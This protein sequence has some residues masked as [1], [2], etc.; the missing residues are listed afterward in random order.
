MIRLKAYSLL[1]TIWA[2][3]IWGAAVTQ[4]V[5][6]ADCVSI[7]EANSMSSSC[8]CSQITTADSLHGEPTINKLPLSFS[9]AYLDW[10]ASQLCMH[11][12]VS[13][14]IT[15]MWDQDVS[16]LSLSSELPEFHAI[17][18]DGL[19]IP[20]RG[21][22]AKIDVIYTPR[23]LGPVESEIVF[24]TSA[25]M[26]LY[27]VKGEGMRN[28][29]KVAPL[30]GFRVPSGMK[31]M[32]TVELHNPLDRPLSIAEIYPRDDF[33]TLMLPAG[34]TEGEVWQIPPHASQP[35]LRLEF[36]PKIAGRYQSSIYV[37]TDADEIV[38]PVEIQAVKD[39]GLLRLEDKLDFGMLTIPYEWRTV[40]LTLLNSGDEPVKILQVVSWVK[41][42]R[43]DVEMKS[44]IVPPA[45]GREIASITF[46][47]LVDGEFHGSVMVRTNDTSSAGPNVEVPYVANVLFGSLTYNVTETVFP[48]TRL[49][50]DVVMN[51]L[52]LHNEFSVP[53]SVND[54]DIGDPRFFIQD[55]VSGG[56]LAPGEQRKVAVI[57]FRSTTPWPN[58]PTPQFAATAS[59]RA[60]SKEDGD[61]EEAT[62]DSSVI[63]TG[64]I[65]TTLTLYTN[66][67]ALKIPL[68]T[69]NGDMV[70]TAS[71]LGDDK[72]A[73]TLEPFDV[74]SVS[75]HYRSAK[76]PTSSVFGSSSSVA[77]HQLKSS[78]TIDFG[79]L[80]VGE[81][82]YKV[83]NITNFNPVPI[84][85][86]TYYVAGLRNADLTFLGYDWSQRDSA[87]D[88]FTN[89]YCFLYVSCVPCW[90]EE[91]RQFAQVVQES[92]KEFDLVLP[93]GVLE[94]QSCVCGGTSGS[95]V[96][97]LPGQVAYFL[98]AIEVDER[99]SW[100]SKAIEGMIVFETGAARSLNEARFAKSARQV[101]SLV[102]DVP[103]A[104]L[105]PK[106]SM[107]INVR[108][109]AVMGELSVPFGGDIDMG[110]ALPGVSLTRAV[111]ASSTY[112]LPARILSI[113]LESSDPS[114]WKVHKIL[115]VI[116]NGDPPLKTIMSDGVATDGTPDSVGYHP[117]ATVE[118]DL[119]WSA[120]ETLKALPS[121]APQPDDPAEDDFDNFFAH[122]TYWNE[123][124]SSTK[125]DLTANISI[126][127]DIFD[128][129][130]HAHASYAYPRLAGAA[131]SFN[132]TQ[133]GTRVSRWID[134]TNPTDVPITC[135]LL[136]LD[137]SRRILASVDNSI[138]V[139]FDS[140]D[141]DIPAE[142]QQLVVLRPRSSGILGP[143]DFS[144][145]QLGMT[146]SYVFIK[147]NLTG[148]EKIEVVGRGGSG[149][150]SVEPMSLSLVFQDADLDSGVSAAVTL[151]NT[152]DLALLVLGLVVSGGD[153][154]S[155]APVPHVDGASWMVG[156]DVDSVGAA[157][158]SGFG[159]EVSPCHGPF[160]LPPGAESVVNITWR[161]EVG[162]TSQGALVSVETWTEAVTFSVEAIA[163]AS[164]AKALLEESRLA[165]RVQ[166]TGT[167]LMLVRSC[168]WAL[169]AACLWVIVVVYQI[170]MYS[171]APPPVT[172][173][174]PSLSSAGL[175]SSK[176]EIDAALLSCRGHADREVQLSEEVTVNIDTGDLNLSTDLAQK[177]PADISGHPVPKQEKMIGDLRDIR[178]QKVTE[179]LSRRVTAISSAKPED[180]DAAAHHEDSTDG[181][182]SPPASPTEE[183][184][185][186]T[187]VPDEPKPTPKPASSSGGDGKDNAGEPP[188]PTTAQ[189][190]PE[191]VEGARTAAEG[192]AGTG[193][194][195]APKQRELAKRDSADDAE[196]LAPSGGKHTGHPPPGAG[197]A[198]G[199][200]GSGRSK[201]D[202]S[203]RQGSTAEPT[204]S[205]GKEK[206]APSGKEG[207]EG[208]HEAKGRKADARGREASAT[209]GGPKRVG[210]GGGS[211]GDED[212]AEEAP[213]RRLSREREKDRD[214]DREKE[215]ESRRDRSRDDEDDRSSRD[216]RGNR[217]RPVVIIPANRLHSS[218]T[219][220]SSPPVSPISPVGLS[221][222]KSRTEEAGETFADAGVGDTNARAPGQPVV[223]APAATMPPISR[224]GGGG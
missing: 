119:G 200:N 14:E 183:G 176:R 5:P 67:S 116:P 171:D 146:A 215:K 65:T 214:R 205:Q 96:V 173:R 30:V 165:Y 106:H 157:G 193:T 22:V 98:F 156:E 25:G 121:L 182:E 172:S 115:N 73:S 223:T 92:G 111:V 178:R 134:V 152:G 164:V 12:S 195:I 23:T 33:L 147:N 201:G 217:R 50:S 86:D 129:T 208:P 117:I 82:R 11:H 20:A 64:S 54:A 110:V 186:S 140:N 131:L 90:T 93:K 188:K 211:R 202:R 27:S 114:M 179:L 168:T 198:G 37:H 10:G 120:D 19:V 151:R 187:A 70:V 153:L 181:S 8:D 7:C 32:Q 38:I 145:Q 158:C 150:L 141:F 194:A 3:L 104:L 99:D 39:G 210:A 57:G 46:H 203:G 138:D 130:V 71:G 49:D 144:P 123:I 59:G 85:I 192:P 26:F 170:V 127:T 60:S 77:V 126:Q 28:V 219:P 139:D 48:M 79:H 163:E 148:F 74:S 222:R 142:A 112:P 128:F 105:R 75:L 175:G 94:S 62:F 53:L 174:G 100:N 68:Y 197:K 4:P 108:Y 166:E 80:A 143:L 41:A 221:G 95:A 42:G 58:L 40:Q 199:S 76:K 122:W 91:A 43:I 52:V 191:P 162:M 103:A 135:Q 34:V 190:H 180:D 207:K 102:R 196:K 29:Y 161:P 56:V 209:G 88:G 87:I 189:A 47:A 118:F 97:V 83:L 51:N 61:N 63:D 109:N 44:D 206:P 1:L 125:P 17:F 220:S 9:P 2:V 72:D 36:E 89:A 169:I 154:G 155:G 69:Y 101:L 45:S 149:K 124:Q 21:G 66:I 218:S 55:F 184:A 107:T 133:I 31:L 167:S 81:S 13:L 6:S 204:R 136:G 24:R 216:R 78:D 213:P 185:T 18:E 113:R 132:M 16:V 224:G 15:N 84:I 160:F 159:F 137:S 212:R 35:V 177:N